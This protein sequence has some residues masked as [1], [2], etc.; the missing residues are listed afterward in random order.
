MTRAVIFIMLVG[1]G[2]FFWMPV[3]GCGETYEGQK[4]RILKSLMEVHQVRFDGVLPKSWEELESG[5]DISAPSHSGTTSRHLVERYLVLDPPV[6]LEPAPVPRGDRGN[7]A[8]R[9][10][11][12]V[13]AMCRTPIYRTTMD[14]TVKGPGRYLVF[15]DTAGDLQ[16]TWLEEK[17]IED[18]FAAAHQVLPGRGAKAV[19]TAGVRRHYTI[20]LGAGALLSLVALWAFW[21]LIRKLHAHVL[22]TRW[23]RTGH[24][25]GQPFPCR[26]AG[27]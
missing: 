6:T 5:L 9:E 10:V 18:K 25:P 15:R 16:W 22:V 26:P 13:L 7:T 24:D 27:S 11:A 1:L 21:P 17:E 14:R 4:A 8:L 19:L 12:E 20:R 23:A 3:G 2:R